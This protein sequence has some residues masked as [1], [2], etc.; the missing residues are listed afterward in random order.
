[1]LDMILILAI[2]YVIF[3]VIYVRGILPF[4]EERKYIK[5]EIERADGVGEKLYW[6]SNMKK[7]Y[8]ELI[9]FYS[10]VSHFMK[11]IAK[12]L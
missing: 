6:E 2:I 4:L 9:P 5:M 7:L 11:K 3:L 8:L 10:S 12:K 1:M